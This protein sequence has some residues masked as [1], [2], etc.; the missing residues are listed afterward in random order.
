MKY[1]LKDSLIPDTYSYNGIELYCC[2]DCGVAGCWS[3]CCNFR[4]TDGLIEM[5]DFRH[6]H[7]KDW[8]YNLH[9]QF[10]KENFF[11]ELNKL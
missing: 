10:S 11:N 6:N 7:R 5:K 2:A 4:E 3:V 9:Y 8:V 1:H